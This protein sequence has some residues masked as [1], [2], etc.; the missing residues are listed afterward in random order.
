MTIRWPDGE[1]RELKGVE[2][3]RLQV[4]KQAEPEGAGRGK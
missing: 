1:V 3:D 2:G 4:I